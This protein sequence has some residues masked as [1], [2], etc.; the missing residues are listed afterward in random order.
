MRN[1]ARSCKFGNLNDGLI[2]NIFT[3]GLVS[4]A[5]REKLLQDDTLN[6]EEAVK[7]CV[8]VEKSKEQSCYMVNR[9]EVNSNLNVNLI[10]KCTKGQSVI[11]SRNK[12]QFRGHQQSGV[13]NIDLPRNKGNRLLQNSGVYY[14]YGGMHGKISVPHMGKS[15]VFAD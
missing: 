10:Q 5:L 6:L 13:K 12:D 3:C 9:Q 2:K 14:R 15:V 11:K 7:L 4:D 1:K 8:S